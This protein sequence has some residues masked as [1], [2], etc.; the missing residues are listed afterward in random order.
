MK[1]LTIIL[2]LLPTL[3]YSQTIL[4]VV[5]KK[6]EK[7]FP[8]KDGYEVN[9][10]GEKAEIVV[11]TWEKAEIQIVMELTAKH[12]DKAI[13]ER[14][15][16]SIKYLAERVKKNIYI[17]NYVSV[18]KE[19]VKPES[20]LSARYT[21]TLPEECGVYLKDYFGQIDVSNLVNKL[22]VYSEFS[23]IGLT[24]L[25]GHIDIKTRFGDLTGNKIDGIMKVNSRRSNITLSELKG[26]FDINSYFG[27]LKIFAD[28]NLIDLNI[29]GEKSDVFLYNSEPLAYGYALSAQHGSIQTLDEVNFTSLENEPNLQKVTFKPG[30]EFYPS[31][32]IS[33]S[34]GKIVVEKPPVKP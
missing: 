6:I 9:V 14:D 26:Q 13:A 16:E 19:Q 29:M 20:N 34:F 32:T 30:Q 28:N 17:R 33:V 31:I 3:V 8:Y 11:E 22:R 5:T 27:I 2:F 15:L 21:I 18:N 25:Q 4:Q 12:P 24:N 7:S 1:Q 10:E 23:T